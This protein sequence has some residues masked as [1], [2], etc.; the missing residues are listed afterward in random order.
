MSRLR[1]TRFPAGS[2]P[3]SLGSSRERRP[4]CRA[5]CHYLRVTNGGR[6]LWWKLALLTCLATAASCSSGSGSHAA[7]RTSATPTPSASPTSERVSRADFLITAENVC[8]DM[9]TLVEVTR[10]DAGSTTILDRLTA[11]RNAAGVLDTMHDSAAAA[12]G[13][14]PRTMEA[15]YR[16]SVVRPLG[17]LSHLFRQLATNVRL[18]N[19]AEARAELNSIPRAAHPLDAYAT[20]YKLHD[21][22]M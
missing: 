1:S 2:P 18:G 9:L 14:A 13:T 20:K 5:V 19:F 17:T 12:A 3:G 21:C 10:L 4:T 15:G 11:L 22:R 6:R 16:R 8:S 7:R